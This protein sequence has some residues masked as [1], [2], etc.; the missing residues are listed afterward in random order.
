MPATAPIRRTTS[1]RGTASAGLG[2]LILAG[3]IGPGGAEVPHCDDPPLE[4]SP[5]PR[6]LAA[7]PGGTDPA[8]VPIDCWRPV[9][10]GLPRD[11]QESE[12]IELQFTLPEGGTCYRLERVDLSESGEAIGVTLTISREPDP[13]RCDDTPTHAVT[14]VD[15]QAP[16]AGRR[17]LDGSR[18]D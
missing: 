3:C 12:R 6:A 8:V 13:T 18:R 11:E 15:L 2:I 16:I 1:R 14:G 5:S 17:L 7:E 10:A 4:P 9:T